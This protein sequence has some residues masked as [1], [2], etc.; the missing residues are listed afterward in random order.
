MKSAS[1][2]PCEV[3]GVFLSVQRQ[4][5]A[6][7]GCDKL[8]EDAVAKELGIPK[9][10]IANRNVPLSEWIKYAVVQSNWAKSST[11]VFE[12]KQRLHLFGTQ[13][14]Q[15]LRPTIVTSASR[16]RSQLLGF[17]T[18]GRNINEAITMLNTFTASLETI[19][20]TLTSMQTLATSASSA[21]MT[22]SERSINNTGTH[23]GVHLVRRH[24]YGCC[25]IRFDDASSRLGSHA[26][27]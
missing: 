21:S 22:D 14:P 6:R 1:S 5:L 3:L 16:Y 20:T 2:L 4:R 9:L 24:L 27:F 19:D 26:D 7:C 17:Q 15:D 10:S 18:A 8:K 23:R 25:P 12:S 13:T 11:G